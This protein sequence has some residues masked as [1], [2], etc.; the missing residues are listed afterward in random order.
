MPELVATLE[1]IYKKDERS[2]KFFAALQGVQIDESSSGSSGSD[3]PVSYQEIQARAMKKLTGNSEAAKAV[4]YGF[5][6][7]VGMSY[8]LIGEE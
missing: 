5:T 7:D 4:E 3:A 6:S 8:S 1:A 2:Q